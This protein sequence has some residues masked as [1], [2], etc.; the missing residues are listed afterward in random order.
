VILAMLLL[1]GLVDALSY[2]LRRR[3]TQ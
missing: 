1:V 2:A 3:L